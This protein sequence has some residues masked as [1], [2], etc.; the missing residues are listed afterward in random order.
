MNEEE[1]KTTEISPNTVREETDTVATVKKTPVPRADQ[2]Q[3]QANFVGE[4]AR[5]VQAILGSPEVAALV[6]RRRYDA[7]RLADGPA[8]FGA[9]NARTF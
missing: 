7:A 2:D 9:L 1:V 3:Q 8:G 5:Q 4:V 6:A